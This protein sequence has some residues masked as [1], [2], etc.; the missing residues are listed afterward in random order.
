MNFSI[1]KIITFQAVGPIFSFHLSLQRFHVYTSN[2]PRSN[3]STSN[4]TKIEL[5][6]DQTWCPLPEDVSR[7]VRL[8]GLG[9]TRGDHRSTPKFDLPVI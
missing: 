5:P 6:L 4:F 3:V 1:A 9:R 2:A 7:I 8:R